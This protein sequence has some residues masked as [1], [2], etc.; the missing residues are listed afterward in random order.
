MKQLFYHAYIGTNSVRGSRGIYSVRINGETL[1]AKIT[2]TAQ[3]Y[4]S[5]SLALIRDGSRLYAA[6]EGMTFEGAA[7]G[8]IVAFRVSADGTLK[9]IN[10][11]RSHGQRSCCAAVNASSDMAAVCNFYRGTCS[12]Y[13][14]DADGALHPASQ[15]LYPPETDGFKALHCVDFITDRYVGVISLTECALIIYRTDT[16]AR[17]TSYEFP[18]HP[19]PRYFAVYDSY[20]YAMMQMPDDIYVF[21]HHPEESSDLELIQKVS[22]LKAGFEGFPATST[23]R[24]TPDGGFLLAANRPT[25]TI[26]VFVREPDG[27]LRRS[28]V[29]RLPGEVPRDFHISRDGRLVVTAL[30]KSNEICVHE[31]DTASG[32]LRQ[33]GNKLAIPSP[34][35]VCVS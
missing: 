31:L 22:V 28:S 12:L 11:Q 19:F 34:A 6:V 32:V 1:E 10:G 3:C 33:R 13:P 30:Q 16:G 5:G 26:S 4:N 35:A 23:I 2:S 7:D 27:T 24:I 14:L 25:N 9:R 15:V 21:R 17:M 8:G 29:C 20:I 18:G